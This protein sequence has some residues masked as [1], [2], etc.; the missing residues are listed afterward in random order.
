M[1]T[2]IGSI[3]P[4]MFAALLLASA[5]PLLPS[6]AARA[7]AA[8]DCLAAP[9]SQAPQGR[10]WYYRIDRVNGRKC[11]Y[12]GAAGTKTRQA[13]PQEAQAAPHVQ[14]PV[15]PLPPLGRDTAGD[16]LP[17]A[18]IESS[19][20]ETAPASI[21]ETTPQGTASAMQWL[22]SPQPAAA[23]Q[24]EPADTPVVDA[25]VATDTQATDAADAAATDAADTAPAVEEA[26]PPQQP[27]AIEA[28][29]S[30]GLTPHWMFLLIAAALAISGI[31][32]P[33]KIAAARQRRIRIGGYRTVPPAPPLRERIPPRLD[34]PGAPPLPPAGTGDDDEALRQ[35]LRS[36]ERRAA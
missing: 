12:L 7:A 8:D 28:A 15:R 25:R 31:V 23:M 6:H 34:S 33:F 17:P 30:T 29:E 24:R 26:A 22:T 1:P 20:K 36:R 18:Q 35:I 4:A 3:A 14:K 10:H 11:W 16:V 13:T 27:A 9:K 5:V 19:S 32:V 2:R 21:A